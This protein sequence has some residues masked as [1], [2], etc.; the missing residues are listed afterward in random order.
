M[1]TFTV[2]T[3]T[4]QASAVIERTLKS[5][6]QQ[7]YAHVEHIIIDGGSTD[8][9]VDAVHRYM[10]RNDRLHLLHQIVLLSEHDGGLYDAMNKGLRMATGNYVVFMNAGDTFHS[11]DTLEHV[12]GS[13][14]DGERL[15]G[16]LYGDTDIVGDDGHFIRRRRLAPPRHLTWRSFLGGM[17]VCHQSFYALTTIA[18]DIPY[19]TDFRFSADIDWCIRVMRQCRRQRLRLKNVGCTLTDYLA[20]GMTADNHNASLKERFSVMKRHYGLLPT[21]AAHAWFVV[22]AVLKK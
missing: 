7:T 10:E 20:G 19:N 14:G 4:W 3:C 17:K 22:R 2:I 15:P 5:V 9:T 21:L 1:I 13:V 8:G 6:L 11:A 18:R 12:S 16:V